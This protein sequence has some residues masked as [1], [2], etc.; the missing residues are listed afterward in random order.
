MI[1]VEPGEESLIREIY[2]LAG[3][4]GLRVTEIRFGTRTEGG[5]YFIMPL[6]I[7]MEGGFQGLLKIL[8]DLRTG[9]RAIRVDG[10]RVSTQERATEVRIVI[11]A[12]AFYAQAASEQ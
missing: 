9:N 1:P 11:S 6:V 4:A 12:N 7:I 8:S 2:H 3:D 5:E 10:V